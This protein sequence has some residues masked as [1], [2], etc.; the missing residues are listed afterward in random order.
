MQTL[1]QGDQTSRSLSVKQSLGNIT[2]LSATTTNKRLFMKRS[3]AAQL[4]TRQIPAVQLDQNSVP[5][6]TYPHRIEKRR[7]EES[8]SE[9]DLHPVQPDFGY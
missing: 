9:T 1:K 8:V 7:D 4:A 3:Q 2:C 6:L 5:V